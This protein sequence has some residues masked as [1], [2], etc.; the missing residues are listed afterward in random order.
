MIGKVNKCTFD[1]SVLFALCCVNTVCYHQYCYK[2]LM[3][4][5]FTQYSAVSLLQPDKVLFL[6]YGLNISLKPRS[7]MEEYRKLSAGKK[8]VKGKFQIDS[9]IYQSQ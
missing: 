2:N 1:L 6:Y 3:A 4:S 9:N 8:R 5:P 7:L